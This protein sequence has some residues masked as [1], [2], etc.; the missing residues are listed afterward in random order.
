MF[1]NKTT[2]AYLLFFMLYKIVYDIFALSILNLHCLAATEG[3]VLF[4]P[5][6]TAKWLLKYITIVPYYRYFLK[7]HILQF[8]L[9]LRP[10][11][12]HNKWFHFRGSNFWISYIVYTA[13]TWRYMH[14]IEYF[15]FTILN[16]NALVFLYIYI[17]KVLKLFNVTFVSL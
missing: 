1:N 14:Y 9:K 15:F 3:I 6:N 4:Q 8:L 16:R 2:Y 17:Y 5:Q 11:I 7:I 12:F 13:L 10:R